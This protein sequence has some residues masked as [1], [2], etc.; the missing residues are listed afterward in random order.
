MGS[1]SRAARPRRDRRVN[2][3]A[4]QD[5]E[6]LAFGEAGG[7]EV[8]GGGAAALEDADLAAGLLG[9]GGDDPFERLGVDV[10]RAGAGH[11]DRSR[12]GRLH[13]QRVQPLVALA[14]G[15]QILARA[16]ELGRVDDQ[17]I[18]G[19]RRGRL[20]E[21]KGVGLDRLDLD[22]VLLGVR[23]RA[24]DRAGRAV[25]GGHRLGA[26]ARGGQREAA[27]VG[28]EIE[29]ARAA[30]PARRRGRGSRAGR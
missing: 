19:A 11:Q 5:F 30:A 6:V 3:V 1:V 29:H 4:E 28:V 24:G 16:R 25:D 10:L 7:Q 2:D 12:R 22:A 17:Q 18:E 21:A 27:G 23:Q 8:V 13:G 20:E 26:A 9:A 15:L 14:R